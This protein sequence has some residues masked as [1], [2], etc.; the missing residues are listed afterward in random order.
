MPPRKPAKKTRPAPKP[1]PASADYT[2]P[3]ADVAS[4]PEIGTQAQFRK[5]K[6]PKTYQ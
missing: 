6:P 2:H 1:R 5:K 3:T 4:R